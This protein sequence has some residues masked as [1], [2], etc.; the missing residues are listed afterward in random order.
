MAIDELQRRSYHVVL[1]DL[2]MPIVGGLELLSRINELHLNVLCII[3]TGF[4]TV[5]TAIDAMK[6]G[7]TTI[8]S[9]R[10]SPSTSPA[11]SVGRSSGSD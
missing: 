11:S 8:C 3:M 9:N 5:E 6:K 2:K 4:G 7:R 1:S 10:S